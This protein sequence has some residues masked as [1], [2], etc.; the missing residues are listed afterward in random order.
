MITATPEAYRL[1]HEGS[2]VFSQME[3]NGIRAD[4]DYLD[5]T[6]RETT[7]LVK[8]LEEEL[9]AD[10]VY[11]AWRRTYGDRLTLGG[12]EQL[13]R[14]LF[15]VM[16]YPNPAGDRT[17]TGK[18][19]TDDEIL[20]KVNCD[21]VPK[22]LKWDNLKKKVLGT[23]LKGIRR[24]VVNGYLHPSFKL[25]SVSTYRSCIAK[26]TLI[27]IVRDCS[28]H[29]KG[30]S[31]EQVKVGDYAYCYDDNLN[32]TIRKVLWAGKTGHRRVIRVHWISGYGKKKGYIDLTPEHRVRLADGRY[33][34]ARYLAE[35]DYRNQGESKRK[36]K[37]SVLAMGREKDRIH[38][39]GGGVFLD[40]RFVYESLVGP[41]EDSDLV[42]HKDNNHFNNLP[43]NL[44]KMLSQSEHAS[45]HAPQCFTDEVR[46]K[47]M[48]R[49]VENH[50]KF[51]DRWP[52]GPEASAWIPLTKYQFL[53]KL[54]RANG[55][56]ARTDIDFGTVRSRAKF[57]GIDLK[58]V[59]DRYDGNGRYI[60]LGRLKRTFP[61]GRAQI[62][63]EFQ[64]GFYKV[65]R[66]LEQRGLS[67][68]RLWGNQF[69]SFVPGNHRIVRVEWIDKVEDVYDLEIEQF[70]NFIANEIC[71]HNSSSDPNFQNIP[72]R[73]PE[74]GKLIR[75]AFIPRK[76][77]HL[78]ECDFKGI[79]VSVGCCYHEDPVMIE[80]VKDKTKDMHRDM[81][82]QIYKVKPS[83]VSKDMR[84]AGKNGFVF[85]EFY[86]SYFAQ[87]APRLWE[88]ISQFK[89][90]LPDGTP[91][92]KHLKR[93]GI[94]ELGSVEGISGYPTR[95]RIATPPGTFM[96]HLRQIEED[97][98]G[99]RFKVYADWKRSWYEQY[100]RDGYFLTHTGFKCVFGKGGLLSKN[101]ATNYPIQG[102]AFH[103]LLWTIIRL[104]KWIKK[105]RMK[106]LLVGQIHDSVEADV[107][108][109][110]LKDYLGKVK[111]IVTVDLPKTWPWIIVPLEIEA[112]VCDR[113]ASW[114]YKKAWV[115][116]Y[117]R[118][119]PEEK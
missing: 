40:H 47:G 15:E 115:D 32:L 3:H 48:K 114:F 100:L 17:R 69:G 82:A 77:N 20:R 95:G 116:K 60:S 24:E 62:K 42:H 104:Q 110:E 50:R 74:H 66:I 21:F 99:R 68:K 36:A 25:H 18:Y 9:K 96:E 4:T 7:Q 28:T 34:Q 72:V 12:R 80:Y 88:V 16:G 92:K 26:G 75:S 78:V 85:P 112:E 51:G 102:S 101:D 111:E 98:W 44:Q 10:K 31:I 13:A 29:P 70:H 63:N 22:Y 46:R 61:L 93:K 97:F 89:L 43:V 49:R 57:L 53:R 27:E 30:I 90:R 37:V 65:K 118:W 84:Y 113:D 5:R 87:C 119:G 108:P 19:R 11:A 8:T 83:E 79:E 94:K 58:V 71:V 55:R 67:T 59:K 23:Y 6:I 81:A 52:K 2:L 86:G 39:T 76:G 33:V 91:L 14:V 35:R 38:S 107:P 117:G 1:L 105:N 45:H 54:A 56:L 103:C 109:D 64:I 106:T 73:D 41:L